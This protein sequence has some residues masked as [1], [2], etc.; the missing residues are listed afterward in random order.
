MVQYGI[1]LNPRHPAGQ[2]GN[3]NEL[4]S[5]RWARI[6][7]KAAAAQ[8]SVE[9]A[10]SFYDPLIDRYNQIGM[11]TLM[12][13][14]QETFWGNGPW[15][16]GDWDRYAREFGTVCGQIAR[17]YRGKGVAYE[18]WNEG[19]IKGISSVFVPPNEFAKVLDAASK[20]IKAVDSNNLVSFGGLASGAQVAVD[21]VKKV[22]TALN[23][24]L[25]VD[26]ISV[27]PYGQ[28]TPN[29]ASQP[30]WGGWFGKLEDHLGIFVS[31]FPN[32]PLW[33]SEIGISEEVNFPP[34]Q[35]PMVVKYM[36]GI[37][38][39]VRTNRFSTH[40]AMV[41]WFAWSDVMRNAGIVNSN[42]TPKT[43][44]YNKFF[45]IARA[46]QFNPPPLPL[47]TLR[48]VILVTT[49]GLSLREGPGTNYTRLT[50]ISKG[51]EVIALE[52]PKS[53]EAK[54]VKSGEWLNIR[55]PLGLV[56]WS[57]A[58]Y[59]K[60]SRVIVAT[61]TGLNIRAG[62][63][64]N[65]PIVTSVPRGALLTALENLTRIG[66]KIG[67]EDRWMQVRTEDG[68]N[69]WAAAWFLTLSEDVPEPPPPP[70]TIMIYPTDNLNI[71]TGPGTGTTRVT[72]VV[73]NTPLKAL[74]SAAQVQAKIGR[75]DQWLNVEAPDQQQ[76]WAAAWFLALQPVSDAV[77]LT[78]TTDLNLR[79][80]P[81]A[82]AERIT[83]MKPGTELTVVSDPQGALNT[84]GVSGWIE[85][86]LP[87]GRTGWT[88]ARYLQRV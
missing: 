9:Q 37:Y 45:E 82:T 18:I 54:L 70:P 38:D 31:A 17:R 87:D 16:N 1:N 47:G 19:D 8:Q 32:I 85:I 63:G 30:E 3:I 11:R 52:P 10:F 57:S 83:I 35:Y 27:H 50:V 2:P 62:N 72:T 28:W 51:A 64:T 75:Q 73:K 33:L 74:E 4:Q 58:Q 81:D 78:P 36:Q 65:H 13:L 14:N 68:K 53:V 77:L 55:T 23:G 42:N 76:G 41:V 25:P 59:L 48:G 60:L 67:R 69:G 24:N 84:L 86:R 79:T 43:Q 61:T 5:V 29:F 80:Q 7:F 22:R 88:A 49:D 56:G 34:E 12:V 66:N 46:T 39:L 26:S 40:V 20:A 44:V 21:Y 6:V 71:R 15:D